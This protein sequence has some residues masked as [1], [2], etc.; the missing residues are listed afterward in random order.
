M[1]NGR[2][3]AIALA[4]STAAGVAGAQ[5]PD[6]TPV[7]QVGVFKSFPGGREI[8]SAYTTGEE[9]S[10]GLQSLVY[11]GRP[12]SIGAGGMK[13]PAQ[14][15]YAWR[16]AGRVESITANEATIRLD[17]QRV[18]NDGQSVTSPGSSVVI[19]K[20]PIGGRKILDQIDGD[21]AEGCQNAQSSIVTFEVR[22]VSGANNDMR[23]AARF[24]PISGAGGTVA[25][26]GATGFGST[27]AQTA[28]SALTGTV[29]DSVEAVAGATVTATDVNTSSVVRTV[30]TNEQGV[31]RIPGLTPGRYT[32]KVEKLGHR[33]ITIPPFTLLPGETR[34]VRRLVL[35]P[36]GP[37]GGTSFTVVPAFDVELWLIH[38]V[39]NRDDEIQRQ[40]VRAHLCSGR[41]EI[42]AARLTC[43][44]T[45]APT[46]F[47][48]APIKIATPQGELTTS[49]L[50]SIGIGTTGGN[51]Q[52]VFTTD[53][54]VTFVPSKKT[55]GEQ[56]SEAQGGGRVSVRLPGPDEVLSFEM[57]PL[58]VPN[59]GSALSDGFAVRVRITPAKGGS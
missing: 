46:E 23:S 32:V 7:V 48:F 52:L 25:G 51:Q 49:V 9:M 37:A 33:P 27:G 30:A 42:V 40:T 55:A 50:G 16:I 12:C 54:R 47:K 14:A 20:L 5:A 24:S 36:D 4:A 39:P 57:P 26:R 17:W 43:E 18:L 31:F 28:L 15:R 8:G 59:G 21:D 38:R 34:D 1:R 53:R 19:T 35:T 58:R 3:L 11:V 13:P 6:A 29:V 2:I 44:G 22:F 56:T 45:S 41:A 10:A